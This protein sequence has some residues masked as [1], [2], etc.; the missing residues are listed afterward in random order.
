MR[1]IACKVAVIGAGAAGLNAMDELLKRGMDAVLFADDIT[2]GASQNS[3][4]DKQ[5]Y[6]KLSLAGEQPDSVSNMAQTLFQGGG[7]RGCHARAMAAGSAR[8][9]LKL[10]LLGV[11]FPTNEW[12]EYVGYQTDHDRTARATSAGPLTSKMMVERLMQSVRARGG[13]IEGGA[14]LISIHTD[15]SGVR[16]A[17]FQ[18]AQGYLAVS[19]A[20][21]I[22]A[23]GGPAS[24]YGRRV[25]PQSQIGATGAALR[26]GAAANNLCYWQYG[27][28]SVGVRWNVSGSYQQAIP[29]YIDESGAPIAPEMDD[30]LT[31]IFL[32]GYQWPFDSARA[33]GSSAIDRAVKAV[34]DAGGRAFLDYTRDPVGDFS[35]LSDEARAYLANCGAQIGGAY[36]RLKQINPAAIAFYESH[37]IDLAREQLEIALCAQHANGGLWVDEHWQTTVPGLYAAGECA[38]VFGAYR[39]GGSALNETQ[40]GSLRA[41]QHICEQEIGAPPPVDGAWVAREVGWMA[42]GA[43]DADELARFQSRMDE[44][45]GAARSVAG[46]RALFNDVCAR[47]DTLSG[48]HAL[49]DVLWTQKFCLSAMLEQARYAGSAG[50]LLTDAAPEMGAHAGYGFVTTQTGTRAVPVEPVPEGDQW[51]E[52]VWRRYVEGSK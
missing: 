52:R 26:A 3:G 42:R 30:R 22:L 35:A 8:A 25:F 51:F 21:L 34:H 16:G 29:E 13:R 32:K 18:T 10:A 41:A 20:K 46:M 43:A 19:C 37:G 28:A 49:R 15:A 11:P 38:G 39:P 7:M 6:Y 47:L 9:F 12:G 14:R 1:T 40:V 4:S 48:D 50:H 27:L 33:Q 5:T 2:G 36:A 44:C 23:T 31:R 24:V 17:L 45:A